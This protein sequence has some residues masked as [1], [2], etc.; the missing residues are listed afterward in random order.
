[1]LQALTNAVLFNGDAMTGS[2]TVMVENGKIIGIQSAD[3][4]VPDGAVIEDLSGLMLVPGFIDVQVNGGGGV[5]F[6]TSRSVEGL[7]TMVDA[8]RNFGTTTL[9]PTLITDTDPIMREAA[10]AVRAAI[11][12]GTLGI[13]GIHF[14]GPCLNPIRKGVHNEDA[15]RQLEEDIEALYLGE[16]LGQV[17][18]TLAPELTPAATISRLRDKGLL[19]CAGH[20]AATYDEARAGLDAGL[21]GFSHLY[22]AM[23]PME[24][25]APGVVGA[26][27]DDADS[28]CGMIV[29][30]FHLYPVTARNAVRSKA[31]GKIMLVTDAMGTVGAE[32][33]SFTL[34]GIRIHAVDG[35]CALDNGTL[36]GSDLDMMSAVRNAH[37]M[38]GLPL[39]EALRMAT[40]YPAEFLKLD[41]VIGRIA[42]GYDADL[43]AINPENLTVRRTWIKGAGKDAG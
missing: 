2:G 30:G 17:I 4:P 9:M 43:A 19:L 25:R 37:K 28:W 32:E 39:E 18:V 15:F 5:M 6:N 7:E 41:D 38:L 34:Y 29:D 20:T 16:G 31:K 42:V 10:D 21:R 35:R 22:N 14:E 8:H 36:A 23:T 40:I 11:A 26:A 1:M 24:N 27:L 3:A 13:R 33:K 12:G